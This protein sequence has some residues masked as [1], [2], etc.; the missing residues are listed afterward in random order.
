MPHPPPPNPYT[1]FQNHLLHFSTPPPS[2]RLTLP[3]TLRASLTLGLNLPLSL[4]LSLALRILYTPLPNFWTPIHIQ[5]IP[6]SSHRTQ[7]SHAA[8]PR[9]KPGFSCAEL[10]ALLDGEE[11]AGERTSW[12]V[13]KINQMHV[14]G[15]WSM[16]ADAHTHVVARGDVEA[17]QRG[18]WEAAVVRRRRGRADVLP[19]WRG[20]PVW[21]AGHSWAVGRLLGV[22]V[23][24][25]EGKEGVER[26]E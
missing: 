16:A 25:S 11:G 2:P 8:L 20:G 14:L 24:D 1:P 26:R 4:L 7:L 23:Y 12:V 3:S 17:F 13:R 5:H 15:F 19:F 18:D 10:L 9:G 22:R 6:P 21:V